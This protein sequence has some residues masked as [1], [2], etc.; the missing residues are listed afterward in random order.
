MGKTIVIVFRD[1]RRVQRL[2]ER[3]GEHGRG[4]KVASAPKDKT[5][6]HSPEGSREPPKDW[7]AVISGVVDNR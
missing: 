2:A 3:V 5:A 7:A 1:G 6:A 4:R